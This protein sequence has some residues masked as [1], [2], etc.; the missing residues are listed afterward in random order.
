MASSRHSTVSHAGGNQHGHRGIAFDHPRE[1]NQVGGSARTV[2]SGPRQDDQPEPDGLQHVVH[3]LERPR[4]VA[5]LA[6]PHSPDRSR[7]RA[8]RTPDRSDRRYRRTRPAR[9]DVTAAPSARQTSAVRPDERPPTKASRGGR[10][11]NLRQCRVTRRPPV[12]EGTSFSRITAPA[13]SNS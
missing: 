13:T 1:R 8:Q 7:P 6:N 5:R 3:R 9:H 12:A 10:R 4:G 11:R 2:R